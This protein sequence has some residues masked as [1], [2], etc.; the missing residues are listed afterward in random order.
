ML[1]TERY[2]FTSHEEQSV[3]NEV[4]GGAVFRVATASVSCDLTIWT[5]MGQVRLA[6]PSFRVFPY[7]MVVTTVSLVSLASTSLLVLAISTIN[8]QAPL[9]GSDMSISTLVAVSP[10]L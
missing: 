10:S 2:T 7:Q 8:L 5:L 3:R 6:P 9:H 4:E 1:P